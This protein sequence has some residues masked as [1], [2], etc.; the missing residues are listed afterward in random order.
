MRFTMKQIDV[1]AFLRNLE[2]CKVKNLPPPGSFPAK[3]SAKHM[4]H[5]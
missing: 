5:G 4:P 1:I 3:L 2:Q